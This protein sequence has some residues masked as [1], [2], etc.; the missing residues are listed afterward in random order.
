MKVALLQYPVVWA[1]VQ[2]NLRRTGLRL[3]AIAGEADVAV[4]PEMFT[5][6]FCPNIP[7]IADSMDGV[8]LRTLRKWAR[9]YNIA[10]LG[11][12][13]C[14]DEGCLYNRGFFV[15]PDG[16][17]VLWTSVICIRVVARRICLRQVRNARWW[18]T[19]V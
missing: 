14:Q 3:Q 4:L 11:S 6:G 12:F 15:K 1:E 13:M 8:T 5:T 18:N 16:E 2:E 7:H 19:K 17:T 9:E 10:V